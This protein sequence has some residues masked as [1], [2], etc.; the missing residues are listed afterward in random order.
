MQ[1]QLCQLTAGGS[2]L[3]GTC[4]ASDPVNLLLWMAL[5]VRVVELMYDS[6]PSKQMVLIATCSLE[7]SIVRKMHLFLICHPEEWLSGAML[8]VYQ[9]VSKEIVLET[10]CH[11]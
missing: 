4:G 6:G 3:V 7:D 11:R 2:N 5:K 1:P 8:L 10:N 9:F